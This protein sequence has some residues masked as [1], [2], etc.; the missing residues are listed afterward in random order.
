MPYEV[1]EAPSTFTC[2]DMEMSHGFT[3]ED[4]LDTQVAEYYGLSDMLHC[5]NVVEIFSDAVSP[6]PG[7]SARTEYNS[8]TTSS[9]LVIWIW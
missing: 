7:I 3:A 5:A 6:E 4:T 9:I 1:L 2:N 8:G